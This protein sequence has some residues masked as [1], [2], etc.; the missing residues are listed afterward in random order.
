MPGPYIAVVI[1]AHGAGRT[2]ESRMLARAI[3]MQRTCSAAAARERLRRRLMN[4]PMGPAFQ[5]ARVESGPRQHAGGSRDMTGL[6][7][8]RGAGERELLRGKAVAV[9]GPGLD[10]HQRL[11]RLDRRTRKRRPGDV[12]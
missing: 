2:Q 10:Q 11:Q 6:A 9:D 3:V 7:T 5:G 12:A 1:D 4:R 8:V